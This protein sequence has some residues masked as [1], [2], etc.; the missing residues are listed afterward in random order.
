[1][2]ERAL[3]GEKLAMVDMLEALGAGFDAVVGASD[4]KSDISKA[5]REL[6]KDAPDMDKVTDALD[7]A[8]AEYNAQ[9]EW[10]VAS[11]PLLADLRIYEDGLRATLGINEQAQISQEQ[12]LFVASCQAQHRDVGL[13]F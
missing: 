9:K 2:K 3:T 5:R 6:K 1:M 8:V 10:R 12:A 4:V 13:N 11:A 7:G